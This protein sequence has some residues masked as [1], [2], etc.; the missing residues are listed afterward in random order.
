VKWAA[1]LLASFLLASALVAEVSVTPAGKIFLQSEGGT[2]WAPLPTGPHGRIPLNP[3]GDLTGD[4]G[5][6]VA[7]S[8][9]SGYPEVVWAGLRGSYEILFA[10]WTGREW[11]QAAV[12]TRSWDDLFPVLVHDAWGNRFVAWV[13]GEATDQ[14][15]ASAAP[16]DSPVFTQPLALSTPDST[17]REPSLAV[18]EDGALLIVWVEASLDEVRLVLAEVLVPRDST[19]LILLG[20][21][22]D[23]IPI[24]IPHLAS[25]IPL[26]RGQQPSAPAPSDLIL[27]GG[28]SEDDPIPI[29]HLASHFYREQALRPTVHSEDGLVWVTWMSLGD[30]EDDDHGPG[31]R[32][33]H[34]RQEADGSV[35]LELSYAVHDGADF[36]AS[37]SV[38]LKGPACDDLE[39]A[40][41]RVRRIVLGDLP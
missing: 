12:T 39:R 40:R 11:R 22:G 28:S 2:I 3:W 27:L 5:P 8:P 29:P 38:P 13:G 23:G 20:G 6:M 1:P 10:E 7:I 31:K 9:A 26:F 4:Q 37:G 30:P 16:A 21:S 41:D 17:A 24:P 18:Q 15:L 14:V 36:A 32:R 33:S 25:D 19:G 34:G 35:Q